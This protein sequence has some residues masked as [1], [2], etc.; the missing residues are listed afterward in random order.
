MM[1]V[2]KRIFERDRAARRRLAARVTPGLPVDGDPMELRHPIPELGGVMRTVVN[3]LLVEKNPFFD[4]VCARWSE[5][6]PSCAARPGRFQDG[7]LF[8][9]VRSSGQVF[10]LRSRLPKIKKALALLPEAPA[11]FSVHLEIHATA[12]FI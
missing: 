8:L 12:A 6:F 5:L 2:E 1:P 4:V 10:S 11:R 9:Y 7:R 3:N